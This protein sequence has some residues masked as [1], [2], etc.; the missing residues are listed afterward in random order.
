[1][2]R[3]ICP[4]ASSATPMRPPRSAP[5]SNFSFTLLTDG[6]PAESHRGQAA[7]VLVRKCAASTA[8]RGPPSW[9]WRPYVAWLCSSAPILLYPCCIST[10][11]LSRAE[12]NPVQ[13]TVTDAPTSAPVLRSRRNSPVFF[14]PARIWGWRGLAV[15]TKK[16]ATEVSPPN[17]GG[18][19]ERGSCPGKAFLTMPTGCH[20]PLSSTMEAESWEEPG[21]WAKKSAVTHNAAGTPVSLTGCS[22][23]KFPAEISVAPDTTGR[24]HV[25]GAD[26]ERLCSTD[27]GVEP[28]WSG[29]VL[30]QGYDGGVASRGLRSTRRVG[31]VLKLAHLTPAFCRQA[32]WLVPVIRSAIRARKN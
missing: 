1:M 12:I 25:V 30:A 24:Q 19:F 4:L 15:S 8:A 11:V 2:S 9:P 7:P 23:L 27:G 29:G 22:K 14:F 18:L 26:G 13:V 10:M 31:M 5:D 28:Q 16:G 17:G 20:G 3:S 32:R 21:H 6:C